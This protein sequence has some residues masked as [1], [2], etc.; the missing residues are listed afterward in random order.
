MND[1]DNRKSSRKKVWEDTEAIIKV[2]DPFSSGSR[3]RMTISGNVDNLSTGGLFLKTMETVPLSSEVEITINFDPAS[4]SGDLSVKAY[5]ET[6]H[7]SDNGVGIR[8]TSIDMVKLQQC[9]IT[10]MNQK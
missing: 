2:D 3:K 5:G 4:P 10:K 6:V 8:F 1:M 9:I 7:V